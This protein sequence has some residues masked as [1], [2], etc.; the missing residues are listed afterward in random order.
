M[1][2]VMEKP[3]EFGTFIHGL[4]K[5]KKYSLKVV[6]DKLGIDI[7]ML[8]KIENGERQLQSHMLNG[9]SEL[10]DLDYKEIQIQLLNQRIDEHFGNEPFFN[11]AINKLAKKHK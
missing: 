3:I 7:S 2:K 10:F 1:I 4:R 5:E 9:L 6:A 8:S 11:E